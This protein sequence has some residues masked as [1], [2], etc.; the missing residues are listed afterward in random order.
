MVAP[1]RR[2]KSKAANFTYDGPVSVIRLEL[3]LTEERTRRRLERHW[4]AVFRVRRALQRDAADRCR[5]YWAAHRERAA[6]PKVARARL[7]LSRKAIE[8]AA[9]A[10]IEASGWMRDHLT[11]AVGLHMADEVWETVDRHVFADSSGRRHGPPRIGSWWDFTRI[12]GRARSHTKARPAW[13]T[14]RLAGTLDGHLATYRH[15]QL[16]EAVHRRRGGCPAGGHSVLAQPA[17]MPVPARPATGS[18]WD[19]SGALAVV[20]TGLA[21]GDLVA[22]VRLPQGAGQWAHLCHFLADPQRLAQD[23]FGPGARPPGAGRLAVLRASADPP[24][25]L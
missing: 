25:R 15:P 24:A 3:D 2:G 19:H 22:P 9:K 14:W 4:G 6:D 11:K 23:R 1:R 21:G 18:W 20:F 7:G 12:P 16:P 8:A 5:A 17:R 13:E 10:H